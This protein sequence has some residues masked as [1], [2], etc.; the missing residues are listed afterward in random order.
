[1]QTELLN[2]TGMTCDGCTSNVM[3]ALKTITGVRDVKV[4]LATGEAA[5]QF[6]ERLTSPEYLKSAVRHA[7]YGVDGT[8]PT[9]SHHGKGSCGGDAGASEATVAL[10]THSRKSKGGCCS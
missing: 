8:E 9:H 5:I 4:S 2:V 6:D 7:G 10:A 1:M 3:N